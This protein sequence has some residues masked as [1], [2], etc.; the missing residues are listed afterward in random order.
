MNKTI[1]LRE[2]LF[3]REYRYKSTFTYIYAFLK[4]FHTNEKKK[5]IYIKMAKIL[6]LIMKQNHR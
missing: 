4:E 5:K 6:L 3:L 2:K 1:K